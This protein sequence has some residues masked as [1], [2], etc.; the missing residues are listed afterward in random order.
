MSVYIALPTFTTPK[1]NIVRF[2]WREGIEQA[3]GT[4]HFSLRSESNSIATGFASMWKL[5][6]ALL[7]LSQSGAFSTFRKVLVIIV[8]I[9]LW[10]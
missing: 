4:Q 9:W 2:G 7:I 5:R 3:R 6:I 8:Y 1:P 10:A